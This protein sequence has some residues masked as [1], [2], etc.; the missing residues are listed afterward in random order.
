MKQPTIAEIEAGDYKESK[1]LNA[2][3][4]ALKVNADWLEHGKGPQHLLHTSPVMLVEGSDEEFVE[5]KVLTI[6]ASAG[7]GYM[8]DY[9][10]IEGGRAY[11]RSFFRKHRTKPESCFRVSIINDS[12]VP[13]LHPGDEALV[14]GAD[15]EIR[16]DAVFAFQVRDEVRIKRFFL[17][18]DGSLRIH[19]DNTRYPDETLPKDAAEAFKVLGRVIDKSGSGGL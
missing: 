4:R 10:A 2:L 12:M 15:S 1:R 17:Q 11:T 13:T 18:S 14:N 16:N 3:A 5:V 9:V 7:G 6:K 8:T 19:S